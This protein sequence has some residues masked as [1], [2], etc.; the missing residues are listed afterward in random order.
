MVSGPSHDNIGAHLG[1]LFHLIISLLIENHVARLIITEIVRITSNLRIVR[2]RV[3]V[4]GDKP[5]AA[6]IHKRAKEEERT[7]NYA[8]ARYPSTVG[9][10][11]VSKVHMTRVGASP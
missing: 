4:F 11:A 7:A 9:K 8:I 2:A 1:N 3:M 10:L 6:L 5:Y